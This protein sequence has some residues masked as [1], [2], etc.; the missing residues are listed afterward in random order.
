MSSPVVLTQST[1][2]SQPDLLIW[3]TL[4]TQSCASTK[5]MPDW[6]QRNLYGVKGFCEGWWSWVPYPMQTLLFKHLLHI[7]SHLKHCDS[8]LGCVMI[9]M[10]VSKKNWNSCF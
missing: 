3:F 2:I 1:V 8:S 5:G 4:K 6:H 9:E 7:T 10:F